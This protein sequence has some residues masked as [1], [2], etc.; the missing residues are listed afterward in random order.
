MG[1]P[2]GA[3]GTGGGCALGTSRDGEPPGG[4]GEV[5]KTGHLLAPGFGGGRALGG[6]GLPAPSPRGPLAWG[7]GTP[8][9]ENS[10]SLA[11]SQSSPGGRE[12]I[13]RWSPRLLPL[14]L[15][16][17]SSLLSSLPPGPAPARPCQAPCPSGC[18]APGGTSRGM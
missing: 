11:S 4:S 15:S 7:V 17:P 2:L 1:R 3:E 13:S 9:A 6:R 18:Q 10:P 16:S 8:G 5:G 12:L 14:P